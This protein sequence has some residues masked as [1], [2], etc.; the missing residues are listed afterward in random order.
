[1][2]RLRQPDCI[3]PAEPR[4][5]ARRRISPFTAFPLRSASH[6]SNTRAKVTLGRSLSRDRASEV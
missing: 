5:G 6:C 4:D 3:R 2:E 1:M